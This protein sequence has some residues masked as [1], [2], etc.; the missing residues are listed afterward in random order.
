MRTLAHT[1]LLIVDLQK[2][3]CAGG[4]L[5]VPEGDG[6]VPVLNRVAARFAAQ[7][8]PVVASR[9]WHPAETSHFRDGGGPWPRHCVA[10]SEGA[11]FHDALELPAGAICVSKGQGPTED[12][13]SAFDGKTPDGRLLEDV[14]RQRGIERLYVGGLATDYCVKHSVL[15]ALRRGFEVTILT[16]AVAAVEL[17]AGDSTRALDEMTAAGAA[18]ATAD[19]CV[20]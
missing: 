13:Y 5:A 2:D 9:D 7:G 6:V 20:P 18:L 4:T 8:A 15:D 11:A 17:H 12:G 16:D 10:G 1:A 19:A 3:F 14:F